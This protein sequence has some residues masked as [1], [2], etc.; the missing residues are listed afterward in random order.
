[1]HTVSPML[2]AFLFALANSQPDADADAGA[3]ELCHTA[4]SKDVLQENEQGTWNNSRHV[5]SALNR[6]AVLFHTRIWESVSRFK[7]NEAALKQKDVEVR[8]KQDERTND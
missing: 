2:R 8:D 6:E 1:M 3:K 5:R 7:H 4:Q